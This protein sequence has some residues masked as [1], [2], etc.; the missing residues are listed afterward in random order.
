M[1]FDSS[2]FEQKSKST[3]S[4]LDKL[5]NSLSFND[6]AKNSESA[7]SSITDNVQKMADKAYTIVD[8][9]ID[10]IK[11]NIA[12]KLV[13]FLQQNTIGQLQAGWQ[14]YA[15]MTT[16]VATLKAQGYAMEQ[17]TDQLE[18]LNYFTDETS[19]NFTAMVS[20]IGKFTASGQSLEDATTAMMGI[21]EWAA[22]SGKNA[23]EA[24]RAMYQLSQALGAGQMRLQD[25]KSVQN[26][27]M[28]TMEFRKNAI[29]AAIAVGTLKDNL[30]GTYTSLINNKVTFSLQNFAESLTQG[31]WFNTQVM[32]TTYKKYSEA[33][34]EIRSVFEE[35]SYMDA[36]GKYTELNTTAEAVKLIKENNQKLIDSFADT[37]LGSDEISSLLSKWK[38][39]EK[40]TNKTVKEYA[41]LY[42]ITEEQ[43]KLQMEDAQKNYAEYL[44]EYAE[45]FTDAEMSAE[46]ALEK[47]HTYVSEYG[48]KAFASAQEAKTFSEAIESAK[49]AAST[50]WTTIYTN[51]FG[52][53]EEAKALWTDLA[54][55]LYDIFVSR[56]W[57]LN[58][59]FEYWHTGGASALESMLD[60]YQKEL[61]SLKSKSSPT[62]AE[63][64]RMRLLEKEIKRLDTEINTVLL[65]GEKT[66]RYA[67]EEEIKAY[68]DEL[69]EIAAKSDLTQADKDRIAALKKE[70]KT[71][72]E[73]LENT[74]FVDGRTE[75]LKGI[76][77][78]AAGF[79]SLLENLRKGWDQVTE[80]NAG[81][82]ALLSFSEKL[83]VDGYRFYKLMQDLGKGSFFIN[84]SQGIKNLISPITGLIRVVGS[85][86]GQFLPKSQDFRQALNSLSSRFKELTEKIRP[87]EETLQRFA[88]ILRGV[89]SLFRLVGKAL[90]GV[91]HKFVQ[92]IVD[93][94]FDSS[95]GIFTIIL[96][97]L[98]QIGDAFFGWE[99]DV[100][101]AGALATVLGFL[102]DILI[103][104]LTIVNEVAKVF[105][106]ILAP[107][108]N[109][110]KNT[111]TGLIDK[112]KQLVGGGK[113]GNLLTNIAN[114]FKDIG[115]RAKKAWGESESLASVFER[116]KG[117][118]GIGNFL[119]M[120]IAMLDNVVTR[121]GKV[122]LAMLGLDEE[123]SNG[124][125]GHA[126]ENLKD[127]FYEVG[128]VIKWLYTNVVRPVLFLLF[129][130]IAACL[131]DIGDAFKTGD[132]MHIL[133]VIGKSVKTIGSL[134]IVKILMTL[135]KLMGSGGLL[136]IFRNTAKTIKQIGSYF[137]AKTINEI[138]TSLL[139][140]AIA[141]GLVVAGLT[142]LTYLPADNLAQLKSLLI[143]T[144]I[145]LGIF[146]AALTV[147]TAFNHGA[148]NIW[149]FFAADPLERAAR[150]LFALTAAI[151]TMIGAVF[152][153][154]LAFKD[155]T[156]WDI[157]K[158]L[159]T[160]LIPVLTVVGT[161]A[162]IGVV[163]KK[164]GIVKHLGAVAATIA[165]IGV[166][167]LFLA[168]A[169]ATLVEIFAATN[170]TA[171]QIWA[172]FAMLLILVAM[173]T[174]V[175]I[176][177]SRMM[178]TVEGARSSLPVIAGII[179]MV[180]ATVFLVI[181]TLDEMVQNVD[182]FPEY[183]AALAIL[184]TT[185]L[186]IS[187][188]FALM[189][190]GTK[191]GVHI[192]AA[193]F[194]FYKLMQVISMFI[195]P[196][197]AEMQSF[198]VQTAMGSAV[199]VGLLVLLI[200]IAI[201][202][203][204]TGVA[205]IMEA[206]SKIKVAQWIAIIGST[207]AVIAGVM[208]LANYLESNGAGISAGSIIAI[209]GTVLTIIIAF[210]IF[211]KSIA[212]T[213]N[214]N[215]LVAKDIIKMFTIIT[216]MISVIVGGLLGAVA[217]VGLLYKDNMGDALTVLGLFA[218][219]TLGTLIVTMY[220]LY[221]AI[222]SLKDVLKNVQKE[223]LEQLRYILMTTFI[224]LGGLMVLLTAC[225]VIIRKAY[226][227]NSTG[228]LGTMATLVGAT[229][230]TIGGVLFGLGL[231][232]KKV[233]NY[234]YDDQTI[235]LIKKAFTFLTII[236]GEFA[237]T[238]IAIKL[239]YDADSNYWAP[240]AA[241][242]A[243]ALA[244]IG[245][246]LLFMGEFLNKF[247]TVKFDTND[248][249]MV[250][251]IMIS[252][253]SILA[254]IG[255]VIVPALESIQNVPWKT[256]IA[257]LL[258]ISAIIGV[259]GLMITGL[260]V[261]NTQFS[262][263]SIAT[264]M[265]ALI[266]GMWALAH[267]LPDI[268]A[269]FS[270][271]KGMELQEL[272][273]GLAAI[274]LPFIVL[275][276]TIMTFSAPGVGEM[277]LK[278][279]F[280]ISA[281]L[282]LI[283][284]ALWALT[285]VGFL[286]KE[287]FGIGEKAGKSFQEGFE[288]A[289]GINSPAK[290]M[291]KDGKYIAQGLNLGIKKSIKTI[292]GAAVGMATVFNDD[293]CDTLGI[294]SPSKVFYEN[295]R[296]VVRGFING[297]DDA[298]S[299]NKQ[300]GAD[301]AEG[302]LDGLNMDNLKNEMSGIF[303]L[304]WESEAS[305]AGSTMG[306]GL[307]D[308]FKK[309]L[310]GED[311]EAL[312]DEEKKAYDGLLKKRDDYVNK[313]LKK[314]KNPYEEGTEEFAK[315][316]ADKLTEL[317]NTWATKNPNDSKQLKEYEDKINK[318]TTKAGKSGGKSFTDII[319]GIFT[320]GL[321]DAV[322]GSGISDIFS[323]GVE[324]IKGLFSGDSQT[325]QDIKDI[326]VGENGVVSQAG[327]AIVDMLGGEDGEV[328]QTFQKLT[329][330]GAMLDAC[331]SAGVIIGE[332]IWEGI[333]E[334][335]SS[336]LNIGDWIGKTLDF[337]TGTDIE[338]NIK[339]SN[340]KRIKSMEE[341]IST[342]YGNDSKYKTFGSL[343][344]LNNNG[345]FFLKNED[346]VTL[347][348]EYKDL[349]D[350]GN[351]VSRID[352]ER[353]LSDKLGHTYSKY[354]IISSNRYMEESG[355]GGESMADIR[356][357]LKNELINQFPTFDSDYIEQELNDNNTIIKE[358]L[359]KGL[360]IKDNNG[361]LSVD[362][363]NP[364]YEKF[365][366]YFRTG[367]YKI[368]QKIVDEQLPQIK[369]DINNLLSGYDFNEEDFNR[370][371]LLL[372]YDRLKDAGLLEPDGMLK[373]T[374]DM[375][376]AEVSSIL[377][378]LQDISTNGL[379]LRDGPT[380]EKTLYD[381]LKESGISAKYLRELEEK[382]RKGDTGAAQ[383][384]NRFTGGKSVD[385]FLKDTIFNDYAGVVR[386]MNS[387][388]Y[389]S[390]SA[391]RKKYYQDKKAFYEA[392]FGMLES[393]VNA[394][395]KKQVKDTI[396]ENERQATIKEQ[397]EIRDSGYA[398]IM[399]QYGIKSENLES[400]R[401]FVK[402]T[403]LTYKD[404]EQIMQLFKEGLDIGWFEI[405]KDGKI[406]AA[407]VSAD[408]IQTIR[409]MLDIKS[410][411]RV[412]ISLMDYFMQGIDIGIDQGISTVLATI[413]K[414]TDLMT[415]ETVAGINGMIS[416]VDDETIQPSITPIFDSTTLQNGVTAM[417][418]SFGGIN[419]M[420]QATVDSF[421]RDNSVNYNGAFN[422]LTN[423]VA[424][425]T[426]VVNGFMQMVAEGDIVTVNVNA[427]ADPNNIYE[428]VVNANRQKFRQTGKNPLAY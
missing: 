100:D 14:K 398:S 296:F 346:I 252:I 9:M 370:D 364:E 89:V 145:A 86:I 185:M 216:I 137:R 280:E 406:K 341:F 367:R 179:A 21:A 172:A 150:M 107:I 359:R 354:R 47:W 306:E 246:V 421:D 101:E 225:A 7:L 294:A 417:A 96:E 204:L 40:V 144:A 404:G 149:D 378:I 288:K 153:M 199:A 111:V 321:T 57:D 239:I 264:G 316:R 214:N 237:A 248:L 227:A 19:Y 43:A 387:S 243:T 249:I 271:F 318:M 181:P 425:L 63:I 386:L 203:M 236:I 13:D 320:G 224:A 78:F 1:K 27:N 37:E 195:L 357:V 17:I 258:G 428:Y 351:T 5:N 283:A 200:G 189:V 350:N 303:D 343:L 54:N 141:L 187:G 284:L 50:V 260:Q 403:G 394:D 304:D 147:M 156:G 282:S 254:I 87:S 279:C 333:W 355:L 408:M 23:S 16:S 85:V 102:R 382:A 51:V 118:S 80:D 245:G 84:I 270:Q 123:M 55:G 163:L 12:N 311:E 218:L 36:E 82:K 52:N 353:N 207:G 381:N 205:N 210:S 157:A 416:A 334:G 253:A 281:G 110:V 209:I 41:E 313:E 241:I 127:V 67:V 295:G 256:M 383:E 233:P 420:M 79:K 121:I 75:M 266:A 415:D 372:I 170:N 46:D 193:G 326:F 108:F 186:S 32:M 64:D 262:I 154:K 298:S 360:I 194:V 356:E 90:L 315:A 192:L 11:D 329:R 340:E 371:Q 247:R 342:A 400:F 119:Q 278:T 391:D 268:F 25:Y 234:E 255:A 30:D 211:A 115:E 59:V 217:I 197:I 230:L 399:K 28:D 309:A 93:V 168:K 272:L 120:L 44:K 173:M 368:D 164:S 291:T 297:I 140:F 273:M 143:G 358:A 42:D 221:K 407:E 208:L 275:T 66:T 174:A 129:D 362:F 165:A 379:T 423:Q 390:M 48:I 413:A 312:T 68:E 95:N 38:K 83:K 155:A 229:L 396:T 212:N 162:L 219:V 24:S 384:L 133:E 39:V 314:W 305:E 62:Q 15:D 405:D 331:K 385:N 352:F 226:G 124:K 302:F 324:K 134:E 287:L 112:I 373:V 322:G 231:F 22:L 345:D 363:E 376:S 60:K 178:T 251:I 220:V 166:A 344:R 160:V 196:L 323:N 31:K 175:S 261:A 114:G 177:M 402:S 250:S 232:L 349:I 299:K 289:E 337:V 419:P 293:F 104:L 158:A 126:I 151:I 92:P 257:A 53:Y 142:A 276:D 135:S 310:L 94:L 328:A 113:G 361:I 395:V 414:M 33:V 20:E 70:L 374:G 45:T 146:V 301:M 26:L 277:F 215:F 2:D 103:G 347:F 285:E 335:I 159:M 34:D 6:A 130:G 263:A 116:F 422:Y 393:E 206:L 152:L 228:Y 109:I 56:L 3:L 97:T 238:S 8:R 213:V 191:N 65:N 222:D 375:S 131:K 240:M 10:K 69:N 171:G 182:K 235:D 167:V 77:A 348:N 392:Y 339:E 139:K 410:P 292:V 300:A 176:I 307:F 49:D 269:A 72:N 4:T 389:G 242:C 18:R 180:A 128:T 122:I 290:A 73:A 317:Q 427:E 223:N 117:G 99:K 125:V 148:N 138:S 397:Q 388:T 244:S 74:I 76:Y 409:Q 369:D 426:G 161:L 58:D 183:M 267:F 136:R 338:K 366:N 332:S 29:E 98:A 81:G 330:D 401:D 412:A 365:M 411:S 286:I 169:L 274:I 418:N 380:I 105:V 88:R 377:S 424:T 198:D 202:Q 336:A 265:V 259:M 308:S 71:L 327:D 188:S 106:G 184:V 61:N 201:R 35:G 325:V 190:R 132:I 91:Y 319:S